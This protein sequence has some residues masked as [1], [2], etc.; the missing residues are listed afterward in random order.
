MKATTPGFG[1][2]SWA[3]FAASAT[4]SA[5]AISIGLLIAAV[6][7]GVAVL[8][9]FPIALLAMIYALIVTLPH[10]L[11]LGLP[12]YILVR[13][14]GR[15]DARAAAAAGFVIGAG[16]MLI[17]MWASSGAGGVFGAPMSLLPMVAIFG[18]GGLA[19]GLAFH[20]ALPEQEAAA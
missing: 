3:L 12:A 16:P 6:E 5:V 10:A 18:G 4:A 15:V 9:M 14:I 2:I 13:A 20:S 8:A 1:A 7:G 11:L 17:L 19:G